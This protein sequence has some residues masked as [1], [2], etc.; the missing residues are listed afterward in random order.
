MSSKQAARAFLEL[1]LEEAGCDCNQT[2]LYL[3]AVRGDI[4]ALAEIANLV[5]E[6]RSPYARWP[7]NINVGSQPYW[8][9]TRLYWSETVPPEQYV[10]FDFKSNKVDVT[11]NSGTGKARIESRRCGIDE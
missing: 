5:R 1:A 10:H 11:W 6:G 7:G 9:G 3:A 2:E 4:S 8:W